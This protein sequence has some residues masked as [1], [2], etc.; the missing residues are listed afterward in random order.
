ML[1]RHSVSSIF[2]HTKNYK[3]RNSKYDLLRSNFKGKSILESMETAVKF[4]TFHLTVFDDE[5]SAQKEILEYQNI[6]VDTS[7]YSE[8]S[9]FNSPINEWPMNGIEFNQ[10]SF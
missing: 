10:V 9:Y 8:I 2:M 3:T 7:T 5:H 6:N 1:F 4:P